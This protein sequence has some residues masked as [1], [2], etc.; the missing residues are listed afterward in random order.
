MSSDP[1][2][3]SP[4]PQ[5][6][7][8]LLGWWRRLS[9]LPGGRTLFGAMLALRVPYS[10][11]LGARVVELAPGFARLELRD[12]RGVRNHL[13][14][15]HAIALA[16]L[17]EL[18]SGLAMT[19]ALPSSVRGIVTGIDVQYLKKARGLLTAET[20][21][22]VPAVAQPLDHEVVAEIRDGTGEAVARVRVRW[23]L[24]PA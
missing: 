19:C 14:S 24:S 22:T 9:P 10:G 8:P 4:A 6:V 7:P 3:H 13:R 1:Q 2:R 15:V 23:R 21:S 20:T 18:T 11:A 12:R 5:P 16:N 17:G